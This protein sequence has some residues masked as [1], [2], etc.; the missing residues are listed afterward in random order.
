VKL[1]YV[2]PRYGD[3][4]VGG[5]ELAV[6]ML[7][8]RVAAR[9]GNEVEVLTTRAVD[10]RTWANE[11]PEGTTTLHGVR[12]HRFTATGRRADFDT[13]SVPYLSR[14]DQL[15]PAE[16]RELLHMQGPVSPALVDAVR[17]SDA[18]LVVASPYLFDPVVAAV[19]A[20]PDRAVL[21]PAAHD[22]A[23]LR[24]PL[25][26]EVFATVRALVFYTHAEQHLVWRRFRAATTPQVVLGLGC[27][28]G[29][30]DEDAARLRLGIGDRPYLLCL[31]R[32]EGAKGTDALARA[33]ARYRERHPGPVA[34]VFV[35][36]VGSAPP[37]HPD[38]VVAGAVD[39][40]TK[41]GALRG[42]LALV[43]PSPY[44]SFGL[45]VLEAWVA[46]TPVVVNAACAAT[47]EHCERSGGGVW[48]RDYEELEVAL[49]RLEA[50]AALRAGL[51]RAGERYART[52]FAW[53][54]L[55]DRYSA[56]LQQLLR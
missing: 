4:V 51:A 11:Y 16:E 47:R 13:A 36:P 54:S 38:I 18:D 15:S 25:F 31:G 42:A 20:A 34:L 30:G 52:R 8:E 40:A 21:H 43:S 41:W 32:V 7:A 37:A 29:P 46:G 9:P 45:V 44:E 22:E 24:L 12:V 1:A 3:E 56:F 55:T 26:R 19:R 17:E 35:G 49:R 23:V 50:S 53:P 5:A 39:D 33:F 14:P 48:A 28:P 27:E 6:R 10:A 2:V